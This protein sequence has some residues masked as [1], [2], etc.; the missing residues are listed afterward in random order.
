[1][2]DKFEWDITQIDPKP[3]INFATVLVNELNLSP[4]FIVPISVSMMGQINWNRKF[5]CLSQNSNSIISV[6]TGENLRSSEN[7]NGWGPSVTT[8]TGEQLLS[9]QTNVEKQLL[10]FLLI[11]VLILNLDALKNV[12]IHLSNKYLI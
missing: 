1:M 9:H 3:C 7:L 10:Y 12:S 11:L 6:L 4:E 5:R 2:I 8:L